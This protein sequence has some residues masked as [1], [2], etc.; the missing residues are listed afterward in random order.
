MSRS[1]FLQLLHL[2]PCVAA[3]NFAAVD[4]A[5]SALHAAS[6][7]PACGRRWAASGLFAVC[8]VSRCPCLLAIPPLLFLFP[9]TPGFLQQTHRIAPPSFFLSSRTLLRPAPHPLRPALCKALPSPWQSPL[10]PCRSFAGVHP[11]PL[12]RVRPDAPPLLMLSRPTLLAPPL[13]APPLISLA[14]LSRSL[15]LCAR[16]CPNTLS[17]LLTSGRAQRLATP[18]LAKPPALPAVAQLNALSRQQSTLLYP[19]LLAWAPQMPC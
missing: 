7:A 14:P 1:F 9:C 17:C 13:R 5:R 4:F 11:L 2:F 3:V 12:L 19:V 6:Q 8:A 16:R 10:R 18:A 15:L